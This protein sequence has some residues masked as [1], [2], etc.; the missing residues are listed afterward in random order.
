MGGAGG[1]RW[2]EFLSFHQ[3]RGR[4]GDTL[5]HHAGRHAGRRVGRPACTEHARGGDLG[6]SDL[7]CA[8]RRRCRSQLSDVVR[9]HYRTDR[10]GRMGKGADKRRHA[11]HHR[12]EPFVALGRALPNGHR[13]GQH[14][15]RARH[16]A[17]R[18]LS[19]RPR[20]GL[21]A[22][23]QSDGDAGGGRGHHA[24][25]DP[26]CGADAV[27]SR[28]SAAANHG[29]GRAGDDRCRPFRIGLAR[30]GEP[31]ARMVAHRV[32]VDRRG[33]VMGRAVATKMALARRGAYCSWA[34]VK[35][36]YA[37]ARHFNCT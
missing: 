26:R 7:G 23:G 28:L 35:C 9:G 32:A 34:V 22:A 20:A 5:L 36:R 3:R 14:C 33:R 15:C 10:L 25:G 21:F 8:A 24:G 2:G 12:H 30:R 11:H 4:A 1:D 31:G 37:T 29:L 27:G 17:L 19:L 18:H 13:A 6:G 16:R